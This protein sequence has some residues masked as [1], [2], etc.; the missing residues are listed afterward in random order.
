MKKS[1]ENKPVHTVLSLTALSFQRA[2]QSSYQ[3]KQEGSFFIKGKLTPLYIKRMLMLH[4][5]VEEEF[6]KIMPLELTIPT[7]SER[8]PQLYFQVQ[9]EKEYCPKLSLITFPSLLPGYQEKLAQLIYETL[10]A[11]E[12]D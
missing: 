9:Q 4:P 6:L 3:S 10:V 2:L 5:E 11:N 7:V 12:T 1:M 8:S